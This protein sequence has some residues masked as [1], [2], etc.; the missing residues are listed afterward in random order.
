MRKR[1]IKIFNVFSLGRAS[2]LIFNTLAALRALNDEADVVHIALLSPPHYYANMRSRHEP[3]CILVVMLVERK[4]PNS[5]L[6]VWCI[7]FVVKSRAQ[8]R[9]HAC[10]ISFEHHTHSCHFC[11]EFNFYHTKVN[12]LLSYTDDY[13]YTKHYFFEKSLASKHFYNRVVGFD[14]V[15]KYPIRCGL[16]DRIFS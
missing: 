6:Y 14:E 2:F 16:E 8:T 13:Y 9:Q 12:I 5:S 4:W 11:F 15:S 3:K 1:L 7:E 10:D